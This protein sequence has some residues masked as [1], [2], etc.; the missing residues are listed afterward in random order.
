MS[1]KEKIIALI[2]QSFLICNP[3][4]KP[5]PNIKD[6]YTNVLIYEDGWNNC[7]KELKKNQKKLIKMIEGIENYGK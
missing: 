4:K 3:W 6:W 2:K 5:E 7:L 1:D